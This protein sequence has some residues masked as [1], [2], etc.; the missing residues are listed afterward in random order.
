MLHKYEMPP[1]GD[2]VEQ[3]TILRWYRNVG[4]SIGRGEILFAVETDKVVMEI[5]SDISGVIS[6]I[7]IGEGESAS[8][9]TVI[10]MI[11]VI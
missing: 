11:D 9:G 4:E 8:P 3:A 6:E 7:L 10:A 1:L 5:E 2:E